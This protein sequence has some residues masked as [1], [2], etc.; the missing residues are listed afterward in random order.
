MQDCDAR[1]P[2]WRIAG[3]SAAPRPRARAR[4]AGVPQRP[5][6][7]PARDDPAATLP[8]AAGGVG[9]DVPVPPPPPALPAVRPRDR[10][11][12]RRGR[13]RVG[14]QDLGDHRLGARHGAGGRPHSAARRP[15]QGGARGDRV[16]GLRHRGARC[17]PA[18]RGG[19]AGRGRAGG[20]GVPAARRGGAR[21][22]AEGAEGG[23]AAEAA[24]EGLVPAAVRPVALARRLAVARG[25]HQQ[26]PAPAAR[27]QGVN[28]AAAA[29]A[30]SAIHDFPTP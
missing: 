14:C 28:A 7:E 12:R 30:G 29:I 16:R 25:L 23:E 27:R 8:D 26:V 18:R 19:W 9:V 11:A 10:Q 20:A 3:A 6:V 22:E 24:D 5:G 2:A 13:P 4:R 15:R 1:C 17:E 21:R